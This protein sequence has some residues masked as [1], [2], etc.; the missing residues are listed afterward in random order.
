MS[1]RKL[2]LLI[3]TQYDYLPLE[4]YQAREA[5]STARP[6]GQEF[7]LRGVAPER[8]LLAAWHG[9]CKVP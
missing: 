7:P 5:L 2:R 8:E 4:T 3:T 9:G 1:T 6:D